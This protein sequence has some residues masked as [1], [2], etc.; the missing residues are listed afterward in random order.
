VFGGG[1]GEPLR[2][3]NVLRRWMKPALAK[4]GIRWRGWHA[5]RRGLGTNLNTLGV[6]GR[7]IQAILRH[8]DLATT[9]AFYVKPVPKQSQAAMKKIQRAFNKKR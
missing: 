7:T 6:D 4:A 3:E 1:T 5:L 9:M 2:L 8:S